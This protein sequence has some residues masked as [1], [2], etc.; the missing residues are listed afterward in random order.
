MIFIG[1]YVFAFVANVLDIVSSVYGL[2]HGFVEL[3]PFFG[4]WVVVFRLFLFAV[5]LPVSAVVGR[6]PKSVFMFFGLLAFLSVVGF[7]Y[8]M[9]FVNNVVLFFT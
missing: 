1:V 2:S 3:N 8:M 5:L 6:N 4:F 9:G 7:V